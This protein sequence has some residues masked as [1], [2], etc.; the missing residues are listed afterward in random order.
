MESMYYIGLDVHKKMISYC[1]KDGSGKI[2]SEG[3]IL[4]TRYDLDCWMKNLPQPGSAAMEA[5]MFT[6]WTYQRSNWIPALCA[7]TPTLPA[8]TLPWPGKNLHMP[9]PSKNEHCPKSAFLGR[10]GCEP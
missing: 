7:L 3:R 6:S 1:I 2:H 4:A 10:G 8:V 5:T 9:G